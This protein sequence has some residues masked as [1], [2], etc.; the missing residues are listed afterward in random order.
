MELALVENL[1]RKDLSP[2]EEA[3]GLKALASTYGYTHEKMAQKLGKSRS[4]ITETLTLAAMPDDIREQ[5]RRADIE[6]KSLLLQIVRQ[7]EPRKMSELVER[8][9]H[10]GSATRQDARR[11]LREAKTA[12]RGRPKNF[13]HRFQP[14][15]RSFTLTL[16]FRKHEVDRNELI[17]ALQAALDELR[18][19]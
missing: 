14:Q 13:V 5:C 4:S 3:D 19:Q 6:S 11:M 7:S 8:L 18:A 1:Q 15:G 12:K 16:Q 9:R 2:F 17:A 10:D